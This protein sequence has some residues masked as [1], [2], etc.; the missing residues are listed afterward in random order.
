MYTANPAVLHAV[1]VPE[2]DAVLELG[3][4]DDCFVFAVELW[5][6]DFA[7]CSSLLSSLEASSTAVIAEA[8]AAALAAPGVATAATAA[9]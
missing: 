2:H 8:K 3:L 9:V 6:L 1:A 5:M 4:E 7:L